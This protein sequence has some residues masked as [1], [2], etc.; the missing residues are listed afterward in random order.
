ME[1]NRCSRCGAFFATDNNVSLSWIKYPKNKT[2]NVDNNT[3]ASPPYRTFDYPRVEKANPS[4][5]TPDPIT[6]YVKLTATHNGL[7]DS[8][9]VSIEVRYLDT[10][11][12]L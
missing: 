2:A 6:V 1:F 12:D 5:P 4:D 10:S 8:Q 7:S 9:T 3:L 11:Y